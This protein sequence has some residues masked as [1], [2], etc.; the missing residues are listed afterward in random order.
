MLD[1]PN[2]LAQRGQALALAGAEARVGET[3]SKTLL[4]MARAQA[5][6]GAGVPPMPGAPMPPSAPPI[7]VR[8]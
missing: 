5:V 4:N 1:A 7:R 8:Q 2:P 6:G 3:K